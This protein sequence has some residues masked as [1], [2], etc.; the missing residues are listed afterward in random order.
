MA[1]NAECVEARRILLAQAE[2]L[3]LPPNFLDQLIDELGGTAA[4]AEMTG[5][6]ARVVRVAPPRGKGDARARGKTRAN[7][8]GPGSG[9]GPGTGAAEGDPGESGAD[10]RLGARASGTT[11]RFESRAEPRATAGRA[12]A[13]SIA[14]DGDVEGVNLREKAAFNRR[15]KLVA[16]IGDAASTGISLHACR[17]AGNQRRRVRHHRAPWSADKAIQQLGRTHRSIRP[18]VR[19]T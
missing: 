4:V 7:E 19:C 10:V 16:V 1:E 13:G 2:D 11:F 3:N 17:G 9:S 12:A 15:D 6:R 14:N 8:L 5:R 18:A